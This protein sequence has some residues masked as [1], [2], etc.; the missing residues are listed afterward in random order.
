MVLSEIS[1]PTEEGITGSWKTL[2][3]GEAQKKNSY[4]N[5]IKGYGVDRECST[6]VM[7]YICIRNCGRESC[8]Q[9]TTPNKWE[10]DHIEWILNKYD[11]CGLDCSALD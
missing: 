10:Q 1:G 11:G 8:W 4:D 3:E 9:Q 2:R 6:L 7:Y 5:E